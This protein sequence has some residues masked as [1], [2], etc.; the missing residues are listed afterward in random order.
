MLK[1]SQAERRP[2][3]QRPRTRGS[4]PEAVSVLYAPRFRARTTGTIGLT[5][6]H[7]SGPTSIRTEPQRHGGVLAMEDLRSSD[8]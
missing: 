1:F 2:R 7:Q 8:R 4:S 5:T 3:T 6:D